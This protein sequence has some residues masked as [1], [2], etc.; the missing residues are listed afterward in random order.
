MMRPHNESDS[1]SSPFAAYLGI[2]RAYSSTI[3]EELDGIGLT[4]ASPMSTQPQPM[5]SMP[6]APLRTTVT[7]GIAVNLST[8]EI[9]AAQLPPIIYSAP[10]Y[11]PQFRRQ[12]THVQHK[13]E[14]SIPVH[15]RWMEQCLPRH[16]Y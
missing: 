6:A 4:V 5:V 14:I 2:S 10:P 11:L 8:A 1:S 13:F 12:V 7:A 15:H 9:H 3:P 16:W